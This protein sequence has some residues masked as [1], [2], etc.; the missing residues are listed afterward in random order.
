MDAIEA[1][2]WNQM[3][4]VFRRLV[5][6]VQESSLP[7]ALASVLFSNLFGFVNV[8]IFNTLMLRRE[9][10][11]LSHAF[12]LKHGLG[13]IEAWVDAQGIGWL[14]GVWEELRHTRQVVGFLV[15]HQKSR[16]SYA[17]IRHDL[18]PALTVAQL[19][20]IAKMY[21]DDQ[22]ETE[23]VSVEV[24]EHLR[25]ALATAGESGKPASGFLLEERPVRSLGAEPENLAAC[26][27]TFDLAGFLVVPAELLGVPH[28]AFLGEPFSTSH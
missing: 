23:S 10:C 8:Q 28:Y 15:I 2:P 16:K 3:T 5:G 27:G 17:E 13:V 14:Q 11:S 7:E 6:H 20:R 24:A 4:H 21:W 22:Y 1:N 18:C 26:L 9:C 25:H 19:D 12:S